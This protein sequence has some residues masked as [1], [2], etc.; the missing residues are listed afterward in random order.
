MDNYSEKERLALE[1]PKYFYEITF[2]KPGGLVMPVIVE[3]TYEDGTSK[4]V[5]YPAQVW[6]KNDA[7]ISKAVTS[8]QRIVKITVDPDLETADVDLSNNSWPA[9]ETESEFEEFKNQKD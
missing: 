1:V 9:E 2:N 6:R 4:K 5:T 8:S 3:Y 7:E